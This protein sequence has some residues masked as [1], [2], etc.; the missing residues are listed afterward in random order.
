MHEQ[1]GQIMD[2]IQKDQKAQLPLLEPG[3]KAECRE[4][5]QGTVHAPCTQIPPKGWANHLSHPSDLTPGPTLTLTPYSVGNQL[6]RAREPAT[7]S[8]SLLLQQGPQ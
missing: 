1:L 8:C 2:K 6:E 4:Q 5:K 7:C 3:A